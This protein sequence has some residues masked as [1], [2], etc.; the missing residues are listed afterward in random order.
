MSHCRPHHLLWTQG[1][2]GALLQHAWLPGASPQRGGR[3][4]AG[5]HLPCR[6]GGAAMPG[7]PSPRSDPSLPRM[8]RLSAAGLY[9][10]GSCC[11]ACAFNTIQAQCH[12]RQLLLGLMLSHV[13][14][15]AMVPPQQTSMSLPVWHQPVQ[16]P[17]VASATL[18]RSY[19]HQE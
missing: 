8:S 18:F 7:Q 1:G 12:D 15:S 10:P 19:I 3:L 16:L 6:P 11:D 17:V 14:A 9:L 5:G 2:G 13:I 4:P